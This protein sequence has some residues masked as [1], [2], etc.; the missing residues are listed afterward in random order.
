MPARPNPPAADLD[1]GQD[2]ET[3][4][5]LGYVDAPEKPTDL[6]RHRFPSKVG[7]APAWLDPL[8]L[9]TPQ[10][11]TCRVTGETMRFLLQVYCPVNANPVDAF[12]RSIFLFISPRGDEVA[13]PGAARAL[14][15]Q[16]PR[17]NPYYADT[18]APESQLAPRE[19]Q[20]AEQELS[21]DCDPWKV[22]TLEQQI[23]IEAADPPA[24]AST[25]PMFVEQEL[26]VEP[27]P[28]EGDWEP[29]TE[30]PEVQRLL[31]AYQSRI[32]A[33]GEYDEQELP[34]GLVDEL[35]SVPGPAQ[36]TFAAFQARTS[37]APEQCVRY[38][39]QPGALPLWPSHLHQP[40][41]SDIPP[42]PHCGRHRQF[43]FQVMPQLLSFMELDTEDPQAPDWGTIAVY[44]CPASCSAPSLDGPSGHSAYIEEFVW[45]QP[46]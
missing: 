43:E 39:F 19:L 41:P 30:S 9:P 8:N 7:G 46:S 6:L 16:L 13:K 25:V 29:G 15:C 35:E 32:A 10:Q 45:V 40:Q 26:V 42:C 22:V 23:A 28:G 36:Q 37:R 34:S 2:E 33:E 12:H 21:L 27:E 14:R 4:Y 5:M 24:A 44:S 11:L 18:P 17:A 31:D 1:E 38:C 20:A 3:V